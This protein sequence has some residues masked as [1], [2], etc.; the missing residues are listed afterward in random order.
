MKIYNIF[1]NKTEYI[2]LGADYYEKQYK[3]EEAEALPA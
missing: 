3:I 1:K 2:N